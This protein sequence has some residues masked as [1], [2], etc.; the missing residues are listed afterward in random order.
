[1]Y[2]VLVQHTHYVDGTRCGSLAATAA[3]LSAAL[4]L[5]SPWYGNLAALDAIL[6]RCVE[7]RGDHVQIVWRNSQD[8]RVALGYGETCRW[9]ED[10]AGVWDPSECAPLDDWLHD[11]RRGVGSTLFDVIVEVISRHKGVALELS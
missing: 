11:A 3:E 5:E 9:L 8:A 4:G 10:R 2:A 6:D 1:V 7:G